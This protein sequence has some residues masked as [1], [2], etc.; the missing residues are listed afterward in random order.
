VLV[1]AAAIVLLV[2]AALAAPFLIPVDSYRPL[3][4]W[5]IEAGTGRQ[6]QIDHLQLYVVP[7]LRIRIVGFHVL[8]PSGFPAGDALVAQSID[9]SINPGALLSRRLDITDI[10]PAGVQ[11]NVLR[12]TTGSSNFAQPVKRTAQGP[13]TVFTLEPLNAVSVNDVQITFGDAPGTKRPA[14]SFTLSGVSGKISSIETQSRDWANQLDIVADLRNAH[15]TTSL[16]N[17]PIDFH[18]GTLSLKAGAGRATFSASVG[19]VNLSGSASFPRLDPLSIAFSVSSPELDLAGLGALLGGGVQGGAVTVSRYPIAHGTIAIGKVLAAP[20]EVTQLKGD[21]AFYGSKVQLTA[22]TFAAYGGHVR[23]SAV[24]HGAAGTPVDATARVAGINVG[25][26]LA[27]LGW[28]NGKVTGAL[29]ASFTFATRL[30]N[31]PEASLTANGTFVVRNGSFPGMDFESNLAQLANLAGI[32]V[33]SGRTQFSYF[34][35]DLRIARERGYSNELRLIATGMTGTARGS[36]GFDQSLS[37]SG[38]G[39]VNVLANGTSSTG[40][41]ALAMV[42]QVLHT[43][44]A[45]NVGSGQVQVPFSL[46]G[47][48]D[49]PQFATAGIAQL[50]TNNIPAQVIQQ[51]TGSS[52]VQSLLKLIPGL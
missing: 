52:A 19:T 10:V 37:Y 44:L 33:P 21:L 16:L 50:I 7:S 11:L 15:L 42:A 39:V 18:T 9:L 35:G 12:N 47:T 38:T 6:V 26:T 27:A 25:Q 32:N 46:H 40:S 30:T 45:Q 48:I 17:K 36:F 41:S 14:P 49:N 43:T 4:V 31:D 5:A 20:V 2:I 34:G 13:A 28:G 29:D 51:Q 24:I 1:A 22:C 23:G 3:L 8:N